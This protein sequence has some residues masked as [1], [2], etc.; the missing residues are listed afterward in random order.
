[1]IFK[2]S[3]FSEKATAF[4]YFLPFIITGHRDIAQLTCIG[5]PIWF[6]LCYIQEGLQ[7]HKL[8]FPQS[9]SFLVLNGD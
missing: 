5:L 4:Y 9:C 1:M 7:R 3:R 2:Y 6:V 8:L